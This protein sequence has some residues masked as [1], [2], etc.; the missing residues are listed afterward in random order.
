MSNKF[1]P[2]AEE[3]FNKSFAKNHWMKNQKNIMFM[4]WS[5]HEITRFSI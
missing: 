5:I 1:S 3:L 2:L 4:P